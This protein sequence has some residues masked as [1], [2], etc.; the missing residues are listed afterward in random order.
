MGGAWTAAAVALIAMFTAAVTSHLTARE[1]SGLVRDAADLHHVRVGTV[2]DAVAV[3][4][5][6]REGIHHRIS[7]RS[8]TG[9]EPWRLASWTLWS[10]TSRPGMAG[11]AGPPE[12]AASVGSEPRS[13]KLCD[14]PSLRQPAPP[15]T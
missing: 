1:L 5:L 7:P 11:A 8:R 13:T 3:S 10:M 2:G 4:Y 6:D 9:C 14:R 15:E 12:R